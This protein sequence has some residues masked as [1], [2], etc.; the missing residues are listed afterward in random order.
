[1]QRIG[2]KFHFSVIF[3]FSLLLVFV[4]SCKKDKYVTADAIVKDI[5]GDCGFIIYVDFYAYQPR[6][7]PDSLKIDSL[8]VEITY[9]LLERAP[10]CYGTVPVEDMLHIQHIK[11]KL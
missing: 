5:S 9:K 1:M 4:A 7:L 11:R 2:R 10:E 6:N 8:Q 3:L